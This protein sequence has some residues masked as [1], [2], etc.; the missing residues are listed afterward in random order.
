VAYSFILD[1]YPAW[2]KTNILTLLDFEKALHLG[3]SVN[4]DDPLPRIRASQ[5]GYAQNRSDRL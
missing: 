3:S 1:R 5:C 4:T 2:S